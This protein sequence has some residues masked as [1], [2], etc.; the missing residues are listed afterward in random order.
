MY[1]DINDIL[2]LVLPMSAYFL[3]SYFRWAGPLKPE[4]IHDTTESH[5]LCSA[6]HLDRHVQKS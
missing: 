1:Y 6:I 2:I 3:L 5:P 4:K